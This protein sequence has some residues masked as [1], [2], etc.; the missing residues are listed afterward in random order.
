MGVCDTKKSEGLRT[1]VCAWNVYG[2]T[3]CAAHTIAKLP[4]SGN[5]RGSSSIQSLQKITDS[6]KAIGYF[7]EEPRKR[8]VSVGENAKKVREQGKNG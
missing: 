1:P 3:V 6:L 5:S 8:C 2:N 4:R 7:C